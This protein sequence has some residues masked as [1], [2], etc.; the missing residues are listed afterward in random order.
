MRSVKI[1]KTML[2]AFISIQVVVVFFYA[3][4]LGT[5]MGNNTP[6]V[7]NVDRFNCEVVNYIQTST[8]YKDI[9]KLCRNI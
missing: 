6:L 7:Q 5:S 2:V 3:C 1:I 4:L 8:E 9:V